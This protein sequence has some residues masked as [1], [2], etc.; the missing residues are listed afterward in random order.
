MVAVYDLGEDE[1]TPYIVMQCVRGETLKEGVAQSAPLS[2]T[3]A[4]RICRQVLEAAGLLR[5]ASLAS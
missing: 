5:R 3:D 2:E 4:G 1:D